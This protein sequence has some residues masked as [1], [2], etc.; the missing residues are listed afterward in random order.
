MS[1][2]IR[3]GV[4]GLGA[5]GEPMAG[6]LASAGLLTMVWNRN[7]GKA[8]QFNRKTGISIAD[9]P[10]QLAVGCNVILT[11]VSA[12]ADLLD[13]IGQILPGSGPGDVVC[14]FSTVAPATA[15][16]VAASLA[17]TGAGFVDAPVSGGVEGGKKGTLSVMAGG[18]SA[19]I[20]RIMPVLE[21]AS[22]TVTL[23]LAILNIPMVVAYRLSPLTYLI[24][25]LLVKVPFFSLVNL[26]AGRKVVTELLQKDASPERISRELQRLLDDPEAHATM[27]EELQLVSRQLGEPGAS[28]RV[29]QLA[30]E[31]VSRG[32]LKPPGVSAM[33]VFWIHPTLRR[34]VHLPLERHD[35]P[36]AKYATYL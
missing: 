9:S 5:M 31:L 30:L 33:S 3:A 10:K 32:A 35:R 28:E 15:K 20:S 11:C 24:G 23:E 8:K 34:R 27:K 7:P 6:H 18:E 1:G 16:K 13:V 29:A 19:N 36:H 2:V 21:A 4:I 12:D 22:G 17:E 26:V 14:D 25:R